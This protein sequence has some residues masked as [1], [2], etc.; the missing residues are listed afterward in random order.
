[1]IY[2]KHD[3]NKI[4]ECGQEIISLANQYENL[5]N[6]IFER[7]NNID[8]AWRGDDANKFINEI[9]SEEN[10]YIR[11]GN[12]L[13]QYGTALTEVSEN[14]KKTVKETDINN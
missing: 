9:K 4:K 14:V 8:E 2:V 6:E 7:L 5:I 1:M 3:T 10:Q 11:F 12:S 13:K